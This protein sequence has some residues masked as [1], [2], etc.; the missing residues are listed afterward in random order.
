MAQVG[1]TKRKEIAKLM[2]CYNL[3]NWPNSLAEIKELSAGK[4]RRDVRDAQGR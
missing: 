3:V 1:Y 2:A 4:E